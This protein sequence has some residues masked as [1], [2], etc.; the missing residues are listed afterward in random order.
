MKPLTKLIL[1]LTTGLLLFFTANYF[2][3]DFDAR[4][5][6]IGINTTTHIAHR[7]G[8][9]ISAIEANTKDLLNTMK[10][11]A[12]GKNIV[13]FGNSMLHSIN[14]YQDGNKLAVEYVSDFLDSLNSTQNIYQ[15]SA[16][17]LNMVEM[18]VYINHIRDSEIKISTLIIPINFRGFQTTKIRSELKEL[19]GFNELGKSLMSQ[20]G[21]L[22]DHIRKEN[23]NANTNSK[24]DSEEKT[25]QDQSESSINNWLNNHIPLFAFRENTRTSIEFMPKYTIRKVFNHGKDPSVIANP[26][27]VEINQAA[28]QEIID[29][30]KANDIRPV[31]YQIPHPGIQ[32][33]FFYNKDDYN[34]FFASMNQYCMNIQIP[35]Y[36]RTEHCIPANLYG[37][38]DE[39]V[40]DVFHFQDEGHKQLSRE[41]IN[42]LTNKN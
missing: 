9:P 42:I 14:N 20:T 33:Y 30:C 39:G 22:S 3:K 18:L 12:S 17:H 7:N 1:I 2:A 16:P 27:D 25:W 41:I 13:W 34:S 37:K 8:K 38:T 32:S 29:L 36:S 10:L 4:A 21:I 19:K 35:F 24:G 23:I 11:D 28:L 40:P 5:V 26:K 31:L 15:F 6:G